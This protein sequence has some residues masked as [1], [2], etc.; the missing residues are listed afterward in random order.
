MRA[1]ALDDPWRIRHADIDLLS[2]ALIDARNLT[3]RW[4]AVFEA[5]G[6]DGRGGRHRSTALVGRPCRLVPGVLD[7]RHVQRQRGAHCSRAALRLASVERHADAWFQQAPADASCRSRTGARLPG[8]DHGHHARLLAGNDPTDDALHFF[9]AALLHEDRVGEHL[10]EI[11][12]AAA[13]DGR[14][15]PAATLAAAAGSRAREAAVDAG[16][17]CH[18]A[19]AGGFVPDNERG[20][21]EVAMP[22]FEIDAQAVSWERYVEFAE[23]GGYDRRE[24][25][26]DTGWDWVQQHGR[27]GPRDV[28]QLRGGVLVMRQ[29]RTAARAA[30]A[31]GAARQPPRGGEAWCRWAGRRLPTEP[32]W[33]LAAVR[34]VTAASSGAMSSSGWPAARAPGPAT[35]PVSRQPG[36]MPA[37]GSQGVLRGAS[38]VTPARWRHPRARRFCT[39]DADS[40]FCGFRS[41]AL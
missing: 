38:W 1:A 15:R 24:L 2:L 9:R 21:H 4:L 26:T 5:R 25:W 8:R 14:S 13:A 41:C 17:G 37:P 40:M 27:R 7:R 16:T 19:T 3:L 22:E 31:A 11:A 18:W 23:D 32:E 29:G 35:A 30:D 36:P 33:E 34:A 39:P 12:A 28:E 6:L 10:A 20:P